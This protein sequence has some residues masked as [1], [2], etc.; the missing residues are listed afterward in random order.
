MNETPLKVI[1]ISVG[2][3][4]GDNSDFMEIPNNTLFRPRNIVFVQPIKKS[5]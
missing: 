3:L 2:L 4:F 5:L 1:Q